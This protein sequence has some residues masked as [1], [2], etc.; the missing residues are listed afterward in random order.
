MVVLVQ[1]NPVL[2]YT[3]SRTPGV[4]HYFNHAV[5]SLSSQGV[6]LEGETFVFT[7]TGASAPAPRALN[8]DAGMSPKNREPKFPPLEQTWGQ[9]LCLVT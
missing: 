4:S 8:L 7:L 2:K 1:L 5:F 9:G 6:I 3:E